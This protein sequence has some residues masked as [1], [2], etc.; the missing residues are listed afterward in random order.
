M[1]GKK[2][3]EPKEKKGLPQK[4]THFHH[5]RKL[6]LY[7]IISFFPRSVT[8]KL[9]R[10]FIRHHRSVSLKHL[11]IQPSKNKIPG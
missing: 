9:K 1:Q 8:H 3:G 10:T 6:K 7:F 5:F 11:N 4:R 2:Q